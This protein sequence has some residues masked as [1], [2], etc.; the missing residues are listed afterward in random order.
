MSSASVVHHEHETIALRP[1]AKGATAARA[2]ASKISATHSSS[3]KLPSRTATRRSSQRSQR[4]HHPPDAERMQSGTDDRGGAAVP[5]RDKDS[6]EASST[7]TYKSSSHEADEVDDIASDDDGTDKQPGAFVRCR[8]VAGPVCKELLRVFCVACGR[9][10][11]ACGHNCL[12]TVR[13]FRVRAARW[14]ERA[15]RVYPLATAE[16]V[17]YATWISRM[18]QMLCTVLHMVVAV[19]AA[20]SEV[21]GASA[22]GHIML[23][24]AV[25]PYV[26]IWLVGFQPALDACSA[27]DKCVYPWGGRK[28]AWYA[29]V[30]AYV[31]L[32]IPVMAMIDVHV[33]VRYTSVRPSDSRLLVFVALRWLSVA[34]LQCPIQLPF[35]CYLLLGIDASTAVDSVVGWIA[36][37]VTL[38]SAIAAAIQFSWLASSQRMTRGQL[39]AA[40][41]RAEMLV[42]HIDDIRDGWIRDVQYRGDEVSQPM[43]LRALTNALNTAIRTGA[44]RLRSLA[45]RGAKLDAS[46]AREFYRMGQRNDRL[47]EVHW[48]ECAKPPPLDSLYLLTTAATRHLTVGF[49]VGAA[50]PP[51]SIPQRLFAVCPSLQTFDGLFARDGELAGHG[52]AVSAV[53]VLDAATIATASEDSVIK[54]WSLRRGG[55]ICVSTIHGHTK[56]LTSISRMPGGRIATGGADGLAKVWRW[57]PLLGIARPHATLRHS[58]AVTAIAVMRSG[59]PHL[60]TASRDMTCR[61]WHVPVP[62][63]AEDCVSATLLG[64]FALSR[65]CGAPLCVAVLGLT[66]MFAVGCQDG[67]IQIFDRDART[68]VAS[69]LSADSAEGELSAD[70]LAVDGDRSSS[71]VGLGTSGSRTHA[72]AGGFV[73][74]VGSQAVIALVGLGSHGRRLAAASGGVVRVF[75]VERSSLIASF[76][77]VAR[78]IGSSPLRTA[79][80]SVPNTVL[81]HTPDGTP[82]FGPESSRLG[83]LGGPRGDIRALSVCEM[84]HADGW[85]VGVG[86]SDGSIQVF[87]ALSGRCVSTLEVHGSGV[88][89]LDVFPD[90]RLVSG[91]SDAVARVWDMNA[92]IVVGAAPAGDRGTRARVTCMARLP[93]DGTLVCGCDDGAVRLWT[94]Q[95]TE[96]GHADRSIG[97]WPTTPQLGACIAVMPGH[98]G[99]V[100]CV[101]TLDLHEDA[102]RASRRRIVSGGRTR[103]VVWDVDHPGCIAVLDGHLDE[104]T[105]IAGL[106]PDAGDDVSEGLLVSSSKDATLKLWSARRALCVRTMRLS[107]RRGWC[108]SLT[109]LPDDRVA[110]G[111]KDGTIEVWDV[112]VGVT[113]ATMTGHSMSVQCVAS[114]GTGLL[115]SGS[116]G[117]VKLWHTGTGRCLT[118]SGAIG[119]TGGDPSD[120]GGGFSVRDPAWV[121]CITAIDDERLAAGLEDGTVAIIDTNGR[122]HATIDVR[123]TVPTRHTDSKHTGIFNA[124]DDT[125]AVRPEGT[126]DA[127]AAAGGS[128]G[129]GALVATASGDV[130]CGAAD[131]TLRVLQVARTVYPCQ[132]TSEGHMGGVLCACPL[133]N[134]RV[135][136]GSADHTVKV[137]ELSSGRREC[138]GN[139]HGATDAVLCLSEL[140]GNR[141]AASCADGQLFV[142]TLPVA[143]ARDAR[144]DTVLLG[145]KQRVK[146]VVALPREHLLIGNIDGTLSLWKLKSDNTGTL[147]ATLRGHADEVQSI[148]ALQDGRVVSASSDLTLRV[149]TDPVQPAEGDDHPSRKCVATLGGH[150]GVVTAV[151]QLRDSRLASASRDGT[152]R[153]W[154][155][156]N[157]D[158]SDAFESGAAESAQTIMRGHAG[159]VSALHVVNE[160]WLASGGSDCTVRIWDVG[161]AWCVVVLPSHAMA[162]TSL[163][164]TGDGRL[165]T[166][167]DD[168]TL[169]L[170]RPLSFHRQLFAGLSRQRVAPPSTLTPQRRVHL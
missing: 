26:C 7:A 16:V 45:V 155:A 63:E 164:V 53:V 87:D 146:A 127:A 110:A 43:K 161:H 140:P 2:P 113:V 31:L 64:T 133:S 120:D 56:A 131:G 19:S 50:A 106:S 132:S 136:S 149:W 157:V 73:D 100:S 117:C 46:S 58:D 77:V 11:A 118:T 109:T 75:D 62:A 159:W 137:W 12:H 17:A 23:A 102:P 35:I 91:G 49:V 125:T 105:A 61:V 66:S 10:V 147:S 168:G 138:V 82:S 52:G 14:W 21:S 76:Q 74:V 163:A 79:V 29:A 65:A 97:T 144:P 129:V 6:D 112:L 20:N 54:V 86:C 4:L 60:I 114:V 130:V 34:V 96:N 81:G 47:M 152:I 88:R 150:T 167:S 36:V 39:A 123:T 92:R 165:V 94:V 160:R 42:P 98:D 51:L 108:A 9:S 28:A 59:A 90:G 169:K 57:H 44:N 32:G 41:L 15:R 8:A 121:D 48:L 25:I 170:W 139:L 38:L 24:V 1:A 148:A 128:V 115:A 69:L 55:G 122:V 89:A 72:G 116:L 153:L 143:P 85:R 22:V 93:R 162:I 67:S 78:P 166:G 84:I 30:A 80:L 70:S 124:Y 134:G 99:P 13:T 158:G 95:E 145:M 107:R 101:A 141:L 33:T 37:V 5:A 83:V 151:V 40:L 119:G 71:S 154:T 104:V 142:W 3:A 156:S 103:L 68:R 111:C 126:V 18:L 135:A 27:S